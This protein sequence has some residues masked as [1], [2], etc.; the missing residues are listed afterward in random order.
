MKSMLLKQFETEIIFSSI[1][2]FRLIVVDF[3]LKPLHLGWL[4]TM[5]FSV[6]SGT[7]DVNDFLTFHTEHTK[8]ITAKKRTENKE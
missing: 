1:I 6:T 7:S 4:L 3:V 5:K 8:C 2:F